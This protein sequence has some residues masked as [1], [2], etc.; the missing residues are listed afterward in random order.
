MGRVRYEKYLGI[1]I[2]GWQ[3][4]LDITD[5]DWKSKVDSNQRKKLGSW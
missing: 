2:P 5:G 1:K 3:I 4:Q